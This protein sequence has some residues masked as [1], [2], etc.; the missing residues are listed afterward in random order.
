LSRRSDP[1]ALGFEVNPHELFIQHSQMKKGKWTRERCVRTTTIFPLSALACLL[2]FQRYTRR[3]RSNS[4]ATVTATGG[5]PHSMRCSVCSTAL[6]PPHTSGRTQSNF[7]TLS[8][9]SDFPTPMF[10][11]CD[12]SLYVIAT[13]ITRKDNDIPS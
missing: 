5:T 12:S 4:T 3:S 7:R 1:F 6:Y 8:G 9:D 2:L 10:R 11:Y 13:T